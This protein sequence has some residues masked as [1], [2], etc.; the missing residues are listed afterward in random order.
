MNARETPGISAPSLVSPEGRSARK[1]QTCPGS[2]LS[3]AGSSKAYLLLAGSS[4]ELIFYWLAPP[5]E[6][7]Y[8]RPLPA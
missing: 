2:Y 5:E 1:S 8:A 3:L 7:P 6:S 4:V